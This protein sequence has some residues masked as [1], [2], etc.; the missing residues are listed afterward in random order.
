V[1][2]YDLIKN[3]AYLTEKDLQKIK[4]IKYGINSLGIY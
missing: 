3:K 2:V 4:N 1:A